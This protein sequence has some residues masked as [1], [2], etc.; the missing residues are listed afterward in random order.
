MIASDSF[1]A[2]DSFSACTDF[3]AHG[4]T[5]S[6]GNGLPEK[7]VFVLERDF[8]RN[9]YIDSNPVLNTLCFKKD[10]NYFIAQSSDASVSQTFAM[11]R[12]N[13]K[14]ALK[15]NVIADPKV[16]GKFKATVRVGEANFDGYRN[17]Y[18]QNS[19]GQG[20]ARVT[21]TSDPYIYTINGCDYTFGNK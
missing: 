17:G 19:K 10:G 8:E 11:G 14:D 1:G 15:I 12:F 7:G 13:K 4:P 20:D 21:F 5:H 18:W 3:S 16:T 9:G 6:C 2:S